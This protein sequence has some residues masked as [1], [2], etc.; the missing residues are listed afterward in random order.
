MAQRLS[1]A[2]A[3][4]RAAQIPFRVPPDEA[5]P[6]RLEAVLDVIYLV[7]NEGYAASAGDAH[8]RQSLCA[9]AVRLAAIVAE[10]MPDEPEALGLLALL[11]LQDSRRDARSGPEGELV[12]LEDQDRTLWNRERIDEGRRILDRALRLRSPGPYQLQAAIAAL[13]TEPQTDWEQIAA[14][15]TQLARVVPSPIVEL[16]RAVAV[17][18]AAGPE[19]GLAL[20]QELPLD[21]YHLY[22]AARADL[23]RRLDRIDEAAA[24]YTRAVELARTDPERRFLTGRLREVTARRS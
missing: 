13:H 16:N 11:L 6:A 9:E 18:M 21:E 8:V 19:R 4:I 2:K 24:A 14:L 23:L 12:L 5:L 7:F 10:L 20:L 15:Y 1:R 3:K 22:H 17:A